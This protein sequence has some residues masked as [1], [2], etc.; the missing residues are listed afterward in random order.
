MNRPPSAAI[1]RAVALSTLAG[2][3]ALSLVPAL[4]ALV[5]KPGSWY[6]GIP[7][8]WWTPPPWLFGPVWTLLYLSMG[9]AAWLVWRRGGWRVQRTAL[10]LF[11]VQLVL[12][13][14]WTPLFFGLKDPLLALLDI[15][16]LAI[17]VAATLVAFYRVSAAAGALLAPYL[18]WVLFASALNGAIWW[19]NPG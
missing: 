19:M 6:Q 3:V 18:A 2:F 1:S 16:L 7:K 13:A 10:T 11:A 15:A 12:N 5:A 9:V 4:G 17:T 8:P 14:L